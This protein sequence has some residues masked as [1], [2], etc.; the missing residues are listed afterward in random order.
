MTAERVIEYL[1]HIHDAARSAEAF[2][3]ELSEQQFLEDQKTQQAVLWNLLVIGEAAAN[4]MNR[5][6]GVVE[7]YPD[8]PWN[9]MKGMRNR[10]AHGYFEVDLRIIWGT[11][12]KD[13]PNLRTEVTRIIESLE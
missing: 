10:I 3:N 5:H 6:S 7:R 8:L 12:R 4:L 11:V 1:T 13:L 9:S 2:V